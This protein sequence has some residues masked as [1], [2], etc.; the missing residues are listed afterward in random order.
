LTE[1]FHQSG[2]ALPEEVNR[3]HRAAREYRDKMGTLPM[4]SEEWERVRAALADGQEALRGLLRSLPGRELNA[5][6][7]HYWLD[8]DNGLWVA[9]APDSVPE[10]S[11]EAV[12]ERALRQSAEELARTRAKPGGSDGLA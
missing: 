11:L 10:E 1:P 8:G 5:G 9:Q 3:Y 12:N 2:P 4:E 6:R 7:L